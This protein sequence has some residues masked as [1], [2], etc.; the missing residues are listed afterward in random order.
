MRRPGFGCIALALLSLLLL[1]PA[2]AS[3]AK[4]K[5]FRAGL[6][7]IYEGSD[8]VDHVAISV[9]AAEPP[10]WLFKRVA[11]GALM[12]AEPECTDALAEGTEIL[13]AISGSVKFTLKGGNDQVIGGDDGHTLSI[14]AGSG[15]DELTICCAAQNILEGGEGDDTINVGG[16][17]N[18]DTIDGGSG[19]DLIVGPKGPDRI[20]GGPGTDTVLYQN[21]PGDSFTVTLDDIENDGLSSAE[22]VHSDIENLTGGQERDHFVGSAAAN[23]LQGHQGND[24]IDGGPGQDTLE[25][26]EDEDRILARDGEPDSVDC[27]FGQDTAMVDVADTVSGCEVVYYPDLDF[28]S[29]GANV[30][31]NDHDASIRPGATDV[32]GDGVDQ[33]CS[34]ADTPLIATAPA[35]PPS[36]SLSGSRKAKIRQGSGSTSFRCRAPAGDTCSVKGSLFQKGKGAKIGSVSGRVGGG[37]TGPLKVHLNGTGRQLLE[38]SGKLSATI[39]ATVANEAGASS[40]FKS[41]IQLKP[42]PKPKQA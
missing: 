11:E 13:C 16:A 32:P 1:I 40:P 12:T 8:S 7:T 2:S 42:S 23:V 30:D 33:D 9:T 39:R 15:E 29:A 26:G 17:I 28:D 3:G 22:D 14:D 37:K 27:G 36:G 35:R 21:P 25:G 6:D 4:A 5:V 19:N 41:T 18:R 10:K 34:G 20:N 38:E 31:C 24:E